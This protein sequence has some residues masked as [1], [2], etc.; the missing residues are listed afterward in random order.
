[1]NEH[2]VYGS[3]EV[4]VH[5]HVNIYVNINCTPNPDKVCYVQKYY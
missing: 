4:G 5:V 2:V 1:M 3:L